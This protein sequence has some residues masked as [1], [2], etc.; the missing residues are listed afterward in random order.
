MQFL[1]SLQS[2]QNRPVELSF[3]NSSTHVS[4]PQLNLV[5]HPSGPSAF[6][7]LGSS[8]APVP[9]MPFNPMMMPPPQAMNFGGFPPQMGYPPLPQAFYPYG[10]Q[11]QPQP[12][13]KN[14]KLEQQLGNLFK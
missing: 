13:N 8:S 14:Q 9:Q 10:A 12:D 11:P 4:H 1:Q 5:D 6:E 3:D 7:F 2:G